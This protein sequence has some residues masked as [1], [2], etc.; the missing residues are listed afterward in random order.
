MELLGVTE[1]YYLIE[2]QLS[3][4]VWQQLS[5]P[6]HD[7]NDAWGSITYTRARHPTQVFRLIKRTI[8]DQVIEP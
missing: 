4:G 7:T 5:A 6:I 2:Y 3:D 8:T 1:S